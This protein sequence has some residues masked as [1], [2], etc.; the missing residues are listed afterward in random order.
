MTKI[1]WFG[2]AFKTV[3]VGTFMGI[4]C[5]IGLV[6]LPGVN[7]A[8]F[9]VVFGIGTGL[10]DIAHSLLFKGRR[11]RWWFK[12]GD[13]VQTKNGQAKGV[14][15]EVVRPHSHPSAVVEWDYDPGKT[16]TIG[17]KFIELE[18]GT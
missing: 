13:R 9:G 4:F 1:D 18:R 15:R 10:G 12:V 16:S 6:P 11:L 5:W 8:L 7:P 14:V 3:F 2:V 17:F